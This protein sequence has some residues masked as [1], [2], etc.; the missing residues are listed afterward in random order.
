M[1]PNRSDLG[2]AFDE[3][4]FA[5]KQLGHELSRSAVMLYARVVVFTLAPV[6]GVVV[7]YRKKHHHESR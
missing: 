7:E 6:V 3:F 5:G 1:N 2:Q 4:V